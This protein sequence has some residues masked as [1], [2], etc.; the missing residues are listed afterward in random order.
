M[1]FSAACWGNLMKLLPCERHMRML[2]ASGAQVDGNLRWLVF[3][4]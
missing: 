3:A 2:R 4:S 1:K